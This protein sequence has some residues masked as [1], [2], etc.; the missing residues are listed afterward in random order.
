MNAT[1]N[2]Q[3]PTPFAVHRGPVAAAADA[4]A[5]TQVVV[6]E[7]PQVK[8]S[9][10]YTMLS[11]EDVGRISTRFGEGQSFQGD[12]TSHK[13][14]VGLSVAG[15]ISGSVQLAENSIF[16][17]VATG[18]AD[19]CSVETSVAVI[20]GRFDGKLNACAIEIMPGADVRG[21][22]HY[23]EIRIHRGARVQA[24]HTIIA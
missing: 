19:A 1:T 11:N 14:N 18:V 23:E 7:H 6:E 22:L 13:P 4:S 10:K 12:Y 17:L 20:E 15:E 24:S 3:I 8:Q 9:S 16:L 21:E 2:E 5:V